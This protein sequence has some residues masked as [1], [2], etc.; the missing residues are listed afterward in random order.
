MD[1]FG[2]VRAD[3]IALISTETGNHTLLYLL[4]PNEHFENQSR[5]KQKHR[6]CLQI[7]QIKHLQNHCNI[8]ISYCEYF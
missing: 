7:K 2:A 5:E 4:I 1:N 3:N 6:N 8:D